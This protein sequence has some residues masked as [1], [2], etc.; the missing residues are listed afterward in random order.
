MC[1]DNRKDRSSSSFPSTLGEFK[2]NTLKELSTLCVLDL[3]YSLG[4][5]SPQVSK[6]LSIVN[7]IKNLKQS[8][9][10]NAKDLDI[11]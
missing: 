10:W 5:A 2:Y 6:L 4:V 3:A 1:S 9:C 8:L 11:K 7:L